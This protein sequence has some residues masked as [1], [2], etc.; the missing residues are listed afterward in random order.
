MLANRAVATG[1]RYLNGCLDQGL[2][3]T[4]VSSSAVEMAVT[5]RR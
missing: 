2:T 4:G 5:L 1:A 3:R